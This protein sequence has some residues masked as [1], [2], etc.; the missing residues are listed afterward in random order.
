MCCPPA[1]RGTVSLAENTSVS[2]RPS[3]LQFHNAGE[4]EAF[5]RLAG[6]GPAGSGRE[7]IRRFEIGDSQGVST[8]L[9]V[10]GNVGIGTTAPASG[11]GVHRVLEIAGPNHAGIIL[12][13]LDAGAGKWEMWNDGGFLRFW[14]SGTGHAIDI[15]P[16]GNVG[17]GTTA[18]T[19]R[20]DVHGNVIASAYFH[21]SDERLKT[22]IASLEN[23]LAKISR[24]QP[25][26]FRWKENNKP[27]IGLIAQNVEKVFPEIVN[28]EEKSGLKS[29]NYSALIPVLIQA[30]NEQ[31]A[32]IEELKVKINER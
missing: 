5:I 7:G 10:T 32:Q 26:S 28:T 21:H 23:S 19:Q 9:T 20:L 8:G 6:G 18:P 14:R 25:V 29:V 22:G 1:N 2:G 17:I 27:S 15:A 24:I 30:I 31:Q 12:T 4:S 11:A 3:W 16:T 13:D